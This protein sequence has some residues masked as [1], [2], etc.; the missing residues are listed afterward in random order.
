MAANG[1]MNAE[2]SAAPIPALAA[3]AV[4]PVA[5]AA[6]SPAVA[7]SAVD[8]EPLN[9][10]PM[11]SPVDIR[12]TRCLR[13]WRRVAEI[14][15]PHKRPLH[16]QSSPEPAQG[17]AAGSDDFELVDQDGVPPRPVPLGPA[18]PG[19]ELLPGV[20]QANLATTALVFMF[21]MDTMETSRSTE[22]SSLAKSWVKHPGQLVCRNLRETGVDASIQIWG[23]QCL[24]LTAAGMINGLEHVIS[25][26]HRTVALSLKEEWQNMVMQSQ[27]VAHGVA[28]SIF[29]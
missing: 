29:H 17:G 21:M 15:D 2:A 25:S 20:L 14:E 12:S 16:P 19:P 27:F 18:A 4:D 11:H 10:R 22:K 6:A 1:M 26:A 7:A 3:S 8:P 5:S 9:E 24:A 13:E 28:C 23:N